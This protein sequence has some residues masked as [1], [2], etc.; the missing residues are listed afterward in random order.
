M[1]LSA[2]LFI[3]L[4]ACKDRGSKPIPAKPAQPPHSEK[5]NETTSPTPSKN[6]IPSPSS[7]PAPETPDLKSSVPAIGDS[8]PTHADK[9]ASE[10]RQEFPS[11][12]LRTLPPRGT[13]VLAPVAT[14]PAQSSVPPY[15]VGTSVDFPLGEAIQNRNRLPFVPIIKSSNFTIYAL[16]W[17]DEQRESMNIPVIKVPSGRSLDDEIAKLDVSFMAKGG[18]V[19][20]RKHFV[21]RG[22]ELRDG[23][24]LIV[25]VNGSNMGYDMKHDHYRQ[26]FVLKTTSELKVVS[27]FGTNG[28]IALESLG[29]QMNYRY[30]RKI[31]EEPNGDLYLFEKRT[32]REG[33]GYTQAPDEC[34]KIKFNKQGKIDL[35]HGKKGY[36]ALPSCEGL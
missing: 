16:S 10:P 14:E 32:L 21:R 15:T 3:S 7:I 12:R 4:S 8:Q 23:S 25:A 17:N 6:S 9:P 22:V 2:L 24:L 30:V 28:V 31:V 1:I 13:V 33:L 11:P 27:S 19:G 5:S 34:Y 20:Y 36:L 35:K 29:T 18:A 26:T